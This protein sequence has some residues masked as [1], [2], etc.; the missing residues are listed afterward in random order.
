MSEQLSA[1]AIR[2]A[3]VPPPVWPA[4]DVGVEKLTDDLGRLMSR[5][6][7]TNLTLTLH[8]V[9]TAGLA[10]GLAEG[11]LRRVVGTQGRITQ[12]SPYDYVVTL[13]GPDRVLLGGD[14]LPGRLALALREL[15][16]VGSP[17]LSKVAMRSLEVRCNE[18]VDPSWLLNE[19][20]NEPAQLLSAQQT[21]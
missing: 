6:G 18:I 5:L 17:A 3:A 9:E 2:A 14:S 11:L 7:A 16:G 1:R 10:P 8:L 21:A 4:V 13:L 19:L 15:L 20:G 12:I